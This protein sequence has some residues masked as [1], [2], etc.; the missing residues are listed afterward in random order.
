[1]NYADIIHFEPIETVVQLRTADSAPDARRLVESFVVSERMADTLRDVIFPQLQFAKPADNKGLFVVGNYGTGKSHMMAVLSAIAEHADLA[2]ALRHPALAKAAEDIAGKF[3]VVRAEIN[4]VMSLRDFFCGELELQ[5]S[6]MGVAYRFPP[7][8]EVRNAKDPLIEMM[9]AFE[10]VYPNQGLLF[11]LDELLDHLRTRK[12]QALLLDL[13]FLRAL[14]EFSQDSRFRFVAGIQEALFD[15]PRFQFVAETLRRVKDRFEQVRIARQDVAF[16]VAERLLKKTAAQQAMVREHLLKFAPLYGHMNERMDEFVRLYPIHPA[17]LETFERVSVAEKREVLKT[18]SAT[19]RQLIDKPIPDDAT[20]LV[21]YD[22]YWPLLRD[23]PSFRADPTI[24]EVIEKSSVL[25]ARVQQAF[26]RP[27]Y[28]AAALRIVHALSVHRLTTDDIYAPIGPTADELRDELCLLVLP[29]PE[30]DAAFLSTIIETVMKELLR[31][32][33]G[34]FLT[35]SIENGQYFLDLKKDTDFDSLIE[36]R[37][38]SI[39]PSHLDR[40]Y[41]DAL[42]RVVFENPDA[43]SYVEGFRIWEHEIE[44]R[45]RKASRQGY[46]FFGAPNE[47]SNAQPPRD[48][49]LYF[50]Q[51]FEPPQFKDEQRDEE[52]FLKLTKRDEAFDRSLRLFAASQDLAGTASGANK[53]TYEDK[54]GQHI[55]A[56]TQWLREK[57]PQALEVSH[58]GR[59]KT[60]LDVVRGRLPSSPTVQDYVNT[61]G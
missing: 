22:G 18:I 61:A 43:K 53:R 2:S 35:H 39:E 1:M 8:D 55:K 11:V 12:D 50:I 15:N 56:L 44:W 38:E 42:R 31:T 32:V 21:A 3:K 41:F 52:V 26:T 5:L 27:N 58:Q 19:I 4:T 46:L 34:Q 45:E 28:K 48:F 6:Q 51:P 13:N 60:L 7:A 37:A 47:R 17:Y 33:S 29:L 57:L 16:V 54:A 49:Y 25:E 59:A 14:G 40:A 30:R 9:A 24:R 23:N 10:A 20:G 36:K